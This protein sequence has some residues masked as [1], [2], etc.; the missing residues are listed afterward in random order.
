MKLK[1]DLHGLSH[2]EA[3]NKTE[4]LLIEASMIKHSEIDIIT[5]NS[6]VLQNKIINEILVPHNFSYYIPSHN[7]GMIVVN[8]YEL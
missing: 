8:D 5:G 2:K 6:S 4:N 3:L 1:I 7:L